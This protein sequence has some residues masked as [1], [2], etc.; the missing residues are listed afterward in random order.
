MLV[1]FVTGYL[2]WDSLSQSQPDYQAKL[3]TEKRRPLAEICTTAPSQLQHF[4]ACARLLKFT[5]K[6]DYDELF[7]LMH[8]DT[9]GLIHPDSIA[10]VLATPE[11][12]KQQHSGTSAADY[13]T[14][15]PVPMRRRL[16][17]PDEKGYTPKANKNTSAT[18]QS[19]I[20]SKIGRIF[21]FAKGCTSAP[22]IV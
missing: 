5:E 4:L 17:Q 2:S 1:H 19:K 21:K 11:K 15:E 8:F 7:E 22:V 10:N 16:L 13:N 20:G 3:L 9:D 14:Q 6:P 18:V 12:A